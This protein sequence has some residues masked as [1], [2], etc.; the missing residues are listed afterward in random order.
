MLPVF[1]DRPFLIATSL[2]TNIYYL[3]PK[4]TFQVLY[5]HFNNKSG[6]VKLVLWAY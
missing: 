2:F 3:K 4:Y 1:L 5:M 6:G